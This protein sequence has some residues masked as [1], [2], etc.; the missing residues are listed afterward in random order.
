MVDRPVLQA[1]SAAVDVA[2][3]TRVARDAAP[4]DRAVLDKQAGAMI[5]VGD[6]PSAGHSDSDEACPSLKRSYAFA[7]GG[8][9]DDRTVHAL[10]CQCDASEQLQLG[11]HLEDAGS[12]RHRARHGLAR[13][14][15][16]RSLDRRGV[17]RGII[18][19]WRYDIGKCHVDSAHERR[20]GYRG[21]TAQRTVLAY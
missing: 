19:D 21:D 11:V 8:L 12:K 14:G 10:A 18:R 17:L 4:R 2:A 16:N 7:I 9:L 6:Q 3:S 15:V 13:R 1:D 5:P 20:D